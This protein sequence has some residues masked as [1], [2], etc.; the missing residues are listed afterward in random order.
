[1]LIIILSFIAI[2]G[3]KTFPG[4]I[5]GLFK[6]LYFP[7]RFIFP[8]FFNT[9]CSILSYLLRLTAAMVGTLCKFIKMLTYF[10]FIEMIQFLHYIFILL[11][12]FKYFYQHR[13]SLLYLK[14]RYWIDTTFFFIK[15]KTSGRY[16]HKKRTKNCCEVIGFMNCNFYQNSIL[17]SLSVSLETTSTWQFQMKYPVYFFFL[18]LGTIIYAIT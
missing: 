4:I 13:K 16:I 1:M 7:E 2:N 3:Q 17:S 10:E 11:Y 9:I 8:S 6:K 12:N 15:H 18:F 14:I 5:W